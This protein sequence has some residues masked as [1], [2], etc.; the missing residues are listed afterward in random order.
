MK[1]RAAVLEAFGK[2]L[3]VQEI[4]PVGSL[5][6]NNLHERLAAQAGSARSGEM[7]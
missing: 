1:I 2:P 7:E 6:R 5:K 4:D 3:E